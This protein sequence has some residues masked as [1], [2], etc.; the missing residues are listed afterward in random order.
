MFAAKRIL[1]V[2]PQQLVRLMGGGGGH[3][4]GPMMPPFARLRPPTESVSFNS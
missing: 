4:H 3:H 1:R 2:K